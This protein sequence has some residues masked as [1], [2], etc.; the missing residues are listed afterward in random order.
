MNLTLF[1]ALCAL[2]LLQLLRGSEAFIVTVDAHNEECFF[3]KVEGG[4]KFG[5]YN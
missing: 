4:T 5:N 3:E 1:G 2:V